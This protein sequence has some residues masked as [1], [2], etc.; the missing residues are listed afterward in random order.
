MAVPEI[1]DCLAFALPNGLFGV[2]VVLARQTHRGVESLA[3]AVMRLALDHPPRAIEAS[4]ADVLI[5]NY[6]GLLYPTA[7]IYVLVASAYAGHA[8]LFTTTG[9][10]SIGREFDLREFVLAGAG[11]DGIPDTLFSQLE[12]EEDS[13]GPTQRL[14]LAELLLPAW[15]G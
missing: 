7:E 9:R 10:L 14:P 12:W 5:I 15:T 13:A 2:A 6:G 8:S 3:V 4:G 1:G 11:W